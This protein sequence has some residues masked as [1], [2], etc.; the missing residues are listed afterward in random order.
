MRPKHTPWLLAANDRRR[1][2]FFI[3]TNTLVGPDRKCTLTVC[4]RGVGSITWDT[5]GGRKA[6]RAGKRRWEYDPKARS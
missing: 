6:E 5:I 1:A 3:I 4:E 2:K